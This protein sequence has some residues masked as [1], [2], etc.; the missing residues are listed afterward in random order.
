MSSQG[1]LQDFMMGPA[2]H[3]TARR[4]HLYEDAFAK[5]SMEGNTSTHVYIHVLH[6]L[7]SCDV[8][9]VLLSCDVL[10]VLLSCDV[11]HVLLSC[12]VWTSHRI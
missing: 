9:C 1:H 10:H 12:D 11:L 3:I 5:L 6:V 2:L 4:T 8:L 7:L